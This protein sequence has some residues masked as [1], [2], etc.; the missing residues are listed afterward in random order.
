MKRKISELTSWKSFDKKLMGDK[1]FAR[2]SKD[3]EFEFLLAN[4]LI[5]ARK[6]R[7]LSQK[8]LAFKIGT[9]QPVISRL[10]SGSA[11]PSISLLSRIAKALDTELVVKFR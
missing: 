7:K 2:V 10:E 5:K 6:R 1:K 4:S 8:E 3:L 9:K 11:S